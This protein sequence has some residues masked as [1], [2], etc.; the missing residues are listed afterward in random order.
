MRVVI[1]SNILVSAIG[2]KSP[3]RK[4]WAAFCE[5]RYK[6]AVSEDILKEYEEILQIHSAPGASD[7]VM[8]IFLESPDVIFQNVYYKWEA[9]R[10]D[11]DDHKFFDVAVAC[12]ADY[13]VTNDRHFDVVKQLPFPK[14]T[15]IS[16]E[17]FLEILD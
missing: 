17:R 6:I 5:G 9:I 10:N 12:A 3:F 13:L 1:D 14:V 11:P 8:E 7:Y 2:K 4:I 15:I 16:A